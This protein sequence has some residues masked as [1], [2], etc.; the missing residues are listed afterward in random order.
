MTSYCKILILF[1]TA[2]H[3]DQRK[4]SDKILKNDK[5]ESILIEINTKRKEDLT[6]IDKLKKY[7][8]TFNKIQ[9]DSS[10]RKSGSHVGYAE[11]LFYKK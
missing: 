10:M 7:N 11:Y 8:F 1:T 9:V 6:I 2:C 3:L 4:K 5:L